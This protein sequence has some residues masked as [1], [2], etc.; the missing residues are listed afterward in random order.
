MTK[1]KLCRTERTSLIPLY[2]SIP[3]LSGCRN[4]FASK[5]GAIIRAEAGSG[6][7]KLHIPDNPC[8]AVNYSQ[9]DEKNKEGFF[10]DC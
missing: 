2:L 9:Q 5:S 6:G 3:K 8:G 10:V 1:V 7:E 4:A